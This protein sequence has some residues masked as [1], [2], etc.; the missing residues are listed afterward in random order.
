[1]AMPSLS[2]H[3]FRHLNCD[4]NPKKIVESVNK[5]IKNTKGLFSAGELFS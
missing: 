3:E 5:H 4:F 2:Y 1:V